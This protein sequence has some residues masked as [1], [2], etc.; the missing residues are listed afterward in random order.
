M[1][2]FAALL[3]E[4]LEKA[5]NA[6]VLVWTVSAR[7]PERDV[8]GGEGQAFLCIASSSSMQKLHAETCGASR[9]H[10]LAPPVF[11]SSE[12]GKLDGYG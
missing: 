10:V 3:K 8:R 1:P 2:V 9:T 11:S 12:E 5:V 6:H 7:D 4:R